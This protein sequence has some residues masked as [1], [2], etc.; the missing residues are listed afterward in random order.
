MND[1]IQIIKLIDTE[2]VN[3]INNFADKLPFSTNTVFW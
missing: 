1:L 2:Q 3:E